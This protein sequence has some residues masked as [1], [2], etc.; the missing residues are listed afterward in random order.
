MF[1]SVELNE[2]YNKIAKDYQDYHDYVL[3][4][5]GTIKENT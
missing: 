3:Y 2:Y 4:A 5:N 1:R